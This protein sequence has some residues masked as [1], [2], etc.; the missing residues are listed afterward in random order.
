MSD[1]AVAALKVL[2]D[3]LKPA[4]WRGDAVAQKTF[5]DIGCRNGATA[6]DTL[7]EIDRLIAAGRWSA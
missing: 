4:M 1:D 3:D 2:L 6:K 5:R 7:D